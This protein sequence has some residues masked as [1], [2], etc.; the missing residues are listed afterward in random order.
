MNEG[1]KKNKRFQNTKFRSQN[2]K[3]IS[4][5]MAKYDDASL[6]TQKNCD[7]VSTYDPKEKKLKNNGIQRLLQIRLHNLYATFKKRDTIFL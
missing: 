5:N 4:G 1:N 6:E 2:L 3:K 7:D